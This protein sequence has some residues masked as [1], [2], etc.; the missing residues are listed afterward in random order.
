MAS[1]FRLN[2]LIRRYPR[3][4]RSRRKPPRAAPQ[5]HISS[6]IDGKEE[7]R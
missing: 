4:R 1:N 2:E 6:S 7:K 3:G 5:P